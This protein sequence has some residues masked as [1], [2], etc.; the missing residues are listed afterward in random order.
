MKKSRCS[1]F[2]GV[3]IKES[4]TNMDLLLARLRCKQWDCEFCA[5]KNRAVWRAHIIDRVNDLGGN[6]LFLTI[7][8]HRN[9]HKQGKTLVNLKTAWKRLYDRLRR[10]F[11]GQKL[12]Y[13]MLFERHKDKEDGGKVKISYHIHAILKAEISGRNVWNAKKEYWYHPEMH[14]W[15]KD[16]A[17]AVGA[18][19]MCH[20]AKIEEANGGLVAAYITKY[21]TKDAQNLTEFPA[22]LR[23]INVSRGFGSP[24]SK[25]QKSGWTFAGGVYKRDALEYGRIVDVTTGEVITV[26]FFAEHEVYPTCEERENGDE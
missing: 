10:K 19:F 15:L 25:R 4:D 11:K 3:V 12:E 6:W 14:T 21:M 13:V 23:R 16:N 20:A 24:D 18:G 26:D 5:R 17:A 8:A 22:R 2:F 7:T 9:A 1:K